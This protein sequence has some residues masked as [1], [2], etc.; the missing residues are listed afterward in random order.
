MLSPPPPSITQRSIRFEQTP[1]PPPMKKRNTLSTQALPVMGK[2]ILSEQIP[3]S[4]PQPKRD[5]RHVQ[6]TTHKEAEE[7]TGYYKGFV[8]IGSQH[9]P[10][11]VPTINRR[12][13]P[14]EITATAERFP[15]HEMFVRDNDWLY[16]RGP[17]V[18]HWHP[19][20]PSFR[21]VRRLHY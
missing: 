5:V 1:H 14:G 19:P 17:V 21:N 10:R 7:S 11:N 15:D 20:P 13:I 2:N 8:A 4:S 3:L 9:F 16:G 12:I 6:M 18:Y